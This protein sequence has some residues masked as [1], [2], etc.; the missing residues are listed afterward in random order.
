MLHLPLDLIS[1]LYF[2]KPSQDI[3]WPQKT[4]KGESEQQV[5][6]WIEGLRM[7]QRLLGLG[8]CQ[9]SLDKIWDFLDTDISSA[10]SICEIF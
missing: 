5:L 9:S 10:L 8:N 1:P 4:S 2:P 3:I 7:H 6:A